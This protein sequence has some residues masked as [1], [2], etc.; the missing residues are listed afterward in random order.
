MSQALSI[1]SSTDWDDTFKKLAARSE[2]KFIVLLLEPSLVQTFLSELSSRDLVGQYY[3]VGNSLFPLDDYLQNDVDTVRGEIYIIS[4]I[5]VTFSLY[6]LIFCIHVMKNKFTYFS[7][8][9]FLSKC[10]LSFE[11]NR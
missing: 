8:I 3:L 11:C 7:S 9:E 10:N 4:V 5:T 6:L 2:A 1:D